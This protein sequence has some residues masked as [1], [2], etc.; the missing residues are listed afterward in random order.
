MYGSYKDLKVYERSYKAA[1]AVY[2]KISIGI[3]EEEKYGIKSQLKNPK[4]R[5]EEEMKKSEIPEGKEEG[6]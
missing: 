5:R 3:P 1:K 2:M 4:F 6:F